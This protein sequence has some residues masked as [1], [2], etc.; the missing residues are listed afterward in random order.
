MLLRLRRLYSNPSGYQIV[1][2]EKKTASTL[3]SSARDFLLFGRKSG[4]DENSRNPHPA[5]KEQIDEDVFGGDEQENRVDVMP[6]K[7]K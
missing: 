6:A 2:Q 1:P 4:E 7:K 3:L 5:E